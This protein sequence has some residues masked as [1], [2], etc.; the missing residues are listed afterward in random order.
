MAKKSAK[1]KGYR[2]TVT[3]K[4]YLTKKEICITVSIVAV[5]VIG[6]IL[7]NL[8]YDDGSLKVVNGVV[9]AKG[10]SLIVNGGTARSPRYFKV[11][12]VAGIDGFDMT[13][14]PVTSDGNVLK[15]IY[16]PASESPID[17]ISVCA[18]NFAAQTF[19][20]ATLASFTSAENVTC[21]E[22]MSAEDDGRAV[23]YF[24]YSTVPIETEPAE[25]AAE[26]AAASDAVYAQVLSAYVDM[27]ERCV[28][29]VVRNECESEEGFVEDSILTGA[30]D[31]AL[32]ALSYETK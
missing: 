25:D 14:E 26:E 19:A 23:S 30:L 18:Y 24:I 20:D 11:G 13:S 2:K 4:P 29:I 1:S 28:N 32:A 31:Q 5:I 22:K 9:Q 10:D 27:G 16:T 6:L 15:Y 7:F 8:L 3:K 12:Q 21:S 17:R